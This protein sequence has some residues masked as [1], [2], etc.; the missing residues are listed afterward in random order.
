MLEKTREAAQAGEFE[1]YK[2]SPHFDGTIAN[3]KWLG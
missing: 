3:P 1:L 2:T